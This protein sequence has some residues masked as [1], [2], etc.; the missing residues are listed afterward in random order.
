MEEK[1]DNEITTWL[2]W[3]NI[4]NEHSDLKT[5]MDKTEIATWLS[6]NYLLR[7]KN[8]NRHLEEISDIKETVKEMEKELIDLRTQKELCEKTLLE[9]TKCLGEGKTKQECREKLDEERN[10]FTE[11][12]KKLFEKCKKFRKGTLSD[13]LE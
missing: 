7:E 5:E 1:D 3:V 9:T 4:L 12:N 10:K 13:L 8:G 2:D 11:M 6:Y